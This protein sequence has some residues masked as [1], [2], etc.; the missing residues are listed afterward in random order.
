MT[1]KQKKQGKKRE[2]R[3]EERKWKVEV[4]TDVSLLNH[5]TIWVKILLSVHAQTLEADSLHL[6]QKAAKCT[7]YKRPLCNCL[8]GQAVTR[9]WLD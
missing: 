9:K 3:R 8:Y 7:T 5:R 2:K 6:K 1:N 4:K